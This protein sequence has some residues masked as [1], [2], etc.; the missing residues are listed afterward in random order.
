MKIKRRFQRK[1]QKGMAT[2]EAVA[3]MVVFTVMLA[4][5]L[6]MFGIIHSGILNSIAARTYAWEVWSHRTNLLFFRDNRQGNPL[7][8]EHF[9]N[10][11]FRAHGI[12]SEKS[13]DDFWYATERPLSIGQPNDEKGRSASVHRGL[14]SLTK[15]E[16][17]EVSPVW[18][19]T[20]YGIC[21]NSQCGVVQ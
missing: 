7:N 1:N 12:S 16:R 9:L 3:L 20:I 18:I 5:G 11:G 8:G 4:Y 2:L 21:L 17:V 14:S 10:F 19:K 13:K 15:R 6:G